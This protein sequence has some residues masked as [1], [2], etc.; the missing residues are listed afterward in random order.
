MSCWLIIKEPVWDPN[1]GYIS[2]CILNPGAF[3][4]NLEVTG[5]NGAIFNSNVVYVLYLVSTCHNQSYPRCPPTTPCSC[6]SPHQAM[7]LLLPLLA[8]TCSVGKFVGP[9]EAGRAPPS[10]ISLFQTFQ[11]QGRIQCCRCKNFKEFLSL[12]LAI[13]STSYDGFL[14]GTVYTF[15][16]QSLYPLW[17]PL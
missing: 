9:W 15:L 1:K 17:P 12:N 16:T 8:G 11:Y 14:L 2:K 4:S 3:L 13:V 6:S 10:D 5:C 7:F